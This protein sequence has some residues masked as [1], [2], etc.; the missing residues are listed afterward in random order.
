M[1]DHKVREVAEILSCDVRVVYNLINTGCLKAYRL[2]KCGTR[3][4]KEELERF[5][6]EPVNPQ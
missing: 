2:G 3:I 1:S 6:N 5:R 4:K